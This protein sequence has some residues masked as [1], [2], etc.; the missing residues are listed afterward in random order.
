M[1]PRDVDISQR[2]MH[3]NAG[4]IKNTTKF[5]DQKNINIKKIT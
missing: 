2:K 3:T 5:E 4:L 1:M